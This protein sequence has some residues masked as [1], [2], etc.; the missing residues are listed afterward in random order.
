MRAGRPDLALNDPQALIL[1]APRV[2]PSCQVLVG[3]DALLA[4]QLELLVEQGVGDEERPLRGAFE[5]LDL[6]IPA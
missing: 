5:R 6:P 1:G 4:W 3:G 2:G